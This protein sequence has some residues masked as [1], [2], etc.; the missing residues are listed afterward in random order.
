MERQN[1]TQTRPGQMPLAVREQQEDEI[2]LVELFYLLWGHALQIIACI[3]LGGAAAFGI[4]YFF[5]RPQY[6]AAAKLYVV[7]A[8]SNSIVNLSD[9]Q[10]GSQLTADYQELLLSRPLLEDV[11]FTL[12]LDIPAEQLDQFIEDIKIENPPNTRI[13][14]IT[15]T[16]PDPQQA[17]EIANEIARQAVLYL[18]DI[19]E[20]PTPHIYESAIV[21]TQKSSPSYTL[22]TLAGALI[23]AALCCGIVAAKYLMNDTFTTSEEISRYFG[24]QPLAVIPEGNLKEVVSK[25]G[26]NKPAVKSLTGTYK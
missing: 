8:S 12:E 17:A 3:I 21:P 23:M 9:L 1:E 13:L 25:H 16:R 10:L 11:I 6:Q 15:V 26:R 2:D 5:I 19:M 18:P 20:S 4:T 7:S 14:S 22:N 24:V